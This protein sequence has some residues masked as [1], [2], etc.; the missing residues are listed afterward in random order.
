MSNVLNRFAGSIW[1]VNPWPFMHDELAH[2]AHSHIFEGITNLNALDL[3]MS[4]FEFHEP[5]KDNLFTE[6]KC[7]LLAGQ[8]VALR[9]DLVIANHMGE[10]TGEVHPAG[11]V[12]QVL[13]GLK[14]DPVLWFRTPDDERHTWDDDPASVDEWF[15]VVQS[16]DA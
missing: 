2:F 15:R 13:T 12:W 7:G 14:S 16:N 6:Y 4:E 9:K 3:A 11:E 8:R 10:P 1:L 5:T